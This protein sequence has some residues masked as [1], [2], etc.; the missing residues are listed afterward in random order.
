VFDL[1]GRPAATLENTGKRAGNAFSWNACHLAGGIYILQVGLDDRI[2][3]K[4]MT[5]LK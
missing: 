3:R 2:I 4:K 5:L 1:N